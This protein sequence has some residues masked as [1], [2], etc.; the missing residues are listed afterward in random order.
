MAEATVAVSDFQ[1]SVLGA[2]GE[3]TAAE[4]KLM[5]KLARE[6]CLRRALQSERD[7]CALFSPRCE[8]AAL[9]A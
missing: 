5:D 1:F 7:Q 6:Q 2:N 8:R 4:I 9:S 3:L